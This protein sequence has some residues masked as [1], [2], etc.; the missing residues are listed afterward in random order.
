[1]ATKSRIWPDV[2]THPGTILAAELS[3]RE[4]S[5]EALASAAGLRADEITEIVERR[6]PITAEVAWGLEQA[7]EGISARFWM[8]VQADYEL[9]M[10]RPSRHAG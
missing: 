4:L 3:A 9:G 5:A 10:A 7:L 8:S 6:A 2:P 1:M